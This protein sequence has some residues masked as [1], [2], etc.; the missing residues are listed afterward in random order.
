MLRCFAAVEYCNQYIATVPQYETS[1]REPWVQSLGSDPERLS[2][3]FHRTVMGLIS[4]L[5]NRLRFKKRD[6]SLLGGDG[7]EV[8]E[9][10]DLSGKPLKEGHLRKSH[11]DKRLLPKRITRRPGPRGK[12]PPKH[13]SEQEA[14]RLF[15]STLR[16]RDRNMRDLR[17][18]EE[19]LERYGLPIWKNE[20]DL[21][22]ALGISVGKLRY[23]SIHR[24]K[25]QAPHYITFAVKKRS[26]GERLI[27]APKRQMKAIQRILLETMVEKLPCSEYAHGFRKQRSVKSGAEA[28]VGKSVV[29]HMD[30]KNFFPTV[31]FG[32]VRGLLIAYGYSYPVASTLAT[33]MTECERQPVQIEEELYH[34]PVS[35]RY[36]VQGAPTSPALCNAILLRFDR[37]MA[38]LARSLGMEYTRYA[39]DITFSGDD[40]SVCARI[41]KRATSIVTSEGFEVNEA[42]TKVM[43][44]GQRQKVTGVTVN[45]TLGLSRKERRKIRAA[46][47]SYRQNPDPAK[48]A[49]IEGKLAWLHMLNPDQAEA[50]REKLVG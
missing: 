38:G 1:Y 21:A 41:I 13:F 43:R 46:I 42:K 2:R 28:H 19:Q 24:E 33:L 35:S 16:T 31:H 26:G 49:E 23:F 18:D 40:K 39:D 14:K 36:C 6:I 50:L 22:E 8:L 11:R 45:E 15:S 44:R 17:E 34:V 4:S 12:K 25:E 37:R 29:I 9:S 32:R 47:H 30:I 7:D 3:D 27:M 20:T 5:L 10:I 48:R